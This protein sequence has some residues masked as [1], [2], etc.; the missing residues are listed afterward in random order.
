MR[1]HFTLPDWSSLALADDERLPLLA[2][3]LLIARD[4]Y[5][6]LD[7]DLYDTMLQSHAEH[8][9]AQ[10]FGVA[11]QHG[12]VK[13]RVQLR[14]L[15]AGDQQCGRKQGQALVVGQRQRRP[16]GQGEMLAHGRSVRSRNAAFKPLSR[17]WGC[18]AR[19]R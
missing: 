3:A 1:E 10:V 18:R 12:V 19:I 6:Q 2:T 17:Q 7:A 13:I 11:L 14:I 4:E 15:V 5:P 16:V 8:L 9:R